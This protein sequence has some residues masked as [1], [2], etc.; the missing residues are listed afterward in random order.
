MKYAHGE[1]IARRFG[2]SC[3]IENV[4][5]YLLARIEA[6]TNKETILTVRGRLEYDWALSAYD[7]GLRLSVTLSDCSVI[8]IGSEIIPTPTPTPTITPF[9]DPYAILPRTVTPTPTPTATPSPTPIQMSWQNSDLFEVFNQLNVASSGTAQQY[10][11]TLSKY[12]GRTETIHENLL[13]LLTKQERD[14]R[15]RIQETGDFRENPTVVPDLPQ[16][17]DSR[18]VVKSAPYH[19][20]AHLSWIYE[21]FNFNVYC[22]MNEFL[23]P[24][25]TIEAVGNLEEFTPIIVR[26]SLDSLQSGEWQSL[27]LKTTESGSVIGLEVSLRDCEIV[28]YPKE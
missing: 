15:Q 18:G 14:L 25:E 24:T 4:D 5:V 1:P 17:T 9:P 13:E 7:G 27:R 10:T 21:D 12:L 23:V 3:Y 2:V 22:Y 26:G 28:Q 11:T 6:L 16:I 19:Y 20:I 8:A